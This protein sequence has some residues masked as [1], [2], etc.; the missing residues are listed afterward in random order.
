MATRPLTMEE[1]KTIMELL[2]NGF[3]YMEDDKEKRFRP[4]HQVALALRLEANLGLRVS[5]VLRL[6][7]KS[8][9]ADKLEIIEKKTNKL[10]YRAI[11]PS[12]TNMIKDYAIEKGL[13]N[14]DNIITISE[15]AIQKQLRIV[16][17]YLQ[18]DNI[19]THSFRKMYA[20]NQ[21]ELNNNNIELIKELLNHSSIAVTQRYIKVSQQAIDKASSSYF[22][23]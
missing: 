12:I 20:T 17:A 11:D 19:S 22:I 18:L 8:F 2:D 7:V 6:Q 15:K 10:Q 21:Y 5:D 1:Y 9:K 3:T 23:G 16:C 4:N 13:K 14:E